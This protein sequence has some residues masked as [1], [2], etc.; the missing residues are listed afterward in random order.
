M[1]TLS[2]EKGGFD[3]SNVTRNNMLGKMG[4]KCP[5]VRT[6]GTTIVGMVFKDGVVLGADTR[7]TEGPIVADKNCEKIHNISNF[8]YCCGAGTA[9]D[10][11]NITDLIRSQLELHRLATGSEP[12]VVTALT[13]LKQ[14]L[15][16][17]HGH[18]SAALV[19]GGVDST[20][21]HLYTV[22]PHGSVDRLP[23]V[24]MGS[25]SLAAMAVFEKDYTDEMDEK[26]AVELVNQAIQAGI[27]NDLGSGSNVDI[28]IIRKD[29]KVEMRRNYVEANPKPPILYKGYDLPKGTTHWLKETERIFKTKVEV[30]DAKERKEA[31]PAAMD[32]A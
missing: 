12:R 28:C 24:T 23:Y 19:L 20:G 29:Q 22:Y 9:A 16:K 13:R 5:K 15:F 2:Q 6:T 7:A 10:T 1:D 26:T 14:R 11:E 25:G 31:A 30:K 27:W 8:I 4:V 18:I 32:T 21:S 17:Y 3:F